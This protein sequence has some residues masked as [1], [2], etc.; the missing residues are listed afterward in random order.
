MKKAKLL[1]LLGVIGLSWA[2]A[3]CSSSSD[4]ALKNKPQKPG[5]VHLR[6]LKWQVKILG[7][8]FR[9]ALKTP[10]TTLMTPR[11]RRM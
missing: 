5:T 10:V 6:P 7:M 8:P 1:S 11:L 9:V 2:L 3:A 4:S